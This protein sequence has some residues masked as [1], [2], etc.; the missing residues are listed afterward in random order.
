M[1]LIKTIYKNT[2]EEEYSDEIQLTKKIIRIMDRWSFI[3]KEDDREK[4]QEKGLSIIIEK[5]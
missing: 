4:L 1:Y 5:V 3:L 2:K